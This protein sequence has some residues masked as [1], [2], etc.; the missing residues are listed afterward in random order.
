M[1]KLQRHEL[2]TES[3][4]PLIS[5]SR[6]YDI[7]G[8]GRRLNQVHQSHK[9]HRPTLSSNS[10][11][12]RQPIVEQ[13]ILRDQTDIPSSVQCNPNSRGS[14]NTN[15]FRTCA[16]TTAS[17]SPIYRMFFFWFPVS[18]TSTDTEIQFLPVFTP[19]KS[20]EGLKLCH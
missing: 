15:Q 8:V 7:L 19:H 13:H 3:L 9:P 2:V 17:S 4:R 20:L 11:C 10:H 1:G 5:V 12:A 6:Q 18:R 16:A 14:C